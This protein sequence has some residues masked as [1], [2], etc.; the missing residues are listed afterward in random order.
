MW[1]QWF[2]G[3]QRPPSFDPDV[4]KQTL[5]P[6]VVAE[7]PQFKFACL[8]AADGGEGSRRAVG[9]V[10]QGVTERAAGRLQ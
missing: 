4:A 5:A 8:R 10:I 3:E 1:G 9:S 2:D 6:H 7:D